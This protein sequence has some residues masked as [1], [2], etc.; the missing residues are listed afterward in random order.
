MVCRRGWFALVGILAVGNAATAAP[1]A[2]PFAAA[3][4]AAVRAAAPVPA[5]DWA[6]LFDRLTVPLGIVPVID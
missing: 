3:P 4:A 2:R 6:H 5:I 1:V